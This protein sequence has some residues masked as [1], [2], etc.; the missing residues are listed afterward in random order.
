MTSPAS[1]FALPILLFIALIGLIGFGAVIPLLPF[2]GAIF[3]APAWQVTLLFS[4]FSVGQFFGE[5]TWGRLSDRYG[6]KPV[7]MT[8]ML[9]AGA[10]FLAF[11]Y[12]PNLWIAILL[13]GACG[14]FAGNMSVVQ[15]Y[16]ADISTRE[17]M[18]GR[19]AMMSTVFSVG[20][21]VGPVLGGLLAHPEVGAAGVRPPI[22]AAAGLYLAA[23]I[24]VA[25]FLRESRGR[26]HRAG[27]PVKQ[28]AALRL[29]WSEPVIRKLLL[30]SLL[31]FSA[32]SLV[33]PS[34]GLWGQVRFGWTPA[35]IGVLMSVSAGAGAVG[36]WVYSR[37][38]AKRV[39]ELATI[40]G[41]LLVAGVFYAGIVLS[42][43]AVI[44]CVLLSAA[45]VAQ[46]VTQPATAGMVSHRSPASHQG[47]I[48]GAYMAVTALGRVS[49]PLIAGAAL[50]AFGLGGPFP[51]AGV[52]L[53]PAV[54]LAYR[55]MQ[56]TKQGPKAEQP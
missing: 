36:Q 29:A 5:L 8:A 15:G 18:R 35:D 48:L 4:V 3:D 53:L 1:P 37:W 45:M 47:A 25:V 28:V 50:S 14:L 40:G 19:L 33:M 30:L 26:S 23:S 31:S 32:F 43:S 52:L 16:I 49:G 13:R 7:L 6:R 20:F 42:P 17:T 56:D 9:G 2:Y 55:A 34:M 46:T 54:W 38:C 39:P 41:G 22:F 27:A 21:V 24:G 12:A 11:A 44:A 51:T 10:M